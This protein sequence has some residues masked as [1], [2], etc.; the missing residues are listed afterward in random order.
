MNAAKAALE[1]CSYLFPHL[2]YQKKIVE[3]SFQRQN[4]ESL[5]LKWREEVLQQRKALG[6]DKAFEDKWRER[7]LRELEER[8]ELRPRREI[9]RK[10]SREIYRTTRR[11]DSGERYD[12]EPPHPHKRHRAGEDPYDYPRR[13]PESEPRRTAEQKKREVTPDRHAPVVVK[14]EPLE[15]PIAPVTVVRVKREEGEEKEEGEISSDE[16]DVGEGTQGKGALA[17]VANY[18]SDDD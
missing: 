11:S 8:M 6:L 17:L 7:E 14:S 15:Q 18:E 4:K 16:D 2:D 3:R 5:E 13:E 1:N 9:A 10:N 12:E